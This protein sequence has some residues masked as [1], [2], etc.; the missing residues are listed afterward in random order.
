M[1]NKY[2]LPVDE[3][4]QKVIETVRRTNKIVLPLAE[5][6]GVVLAEDVVAD[7]DVPMFDRSM[8][9][10]FAV[11]SED[12]RQA[13]IESPVALKVIEEIQAGVVPMR[14]VR[15]GEAARIM[16]G[17]MIPEGAD[18]VCRFE[19]TGDG[20]RQGV[21]T[22]HV[23]RSLESGANIAR[24]GEDLPEGAAVLTEGMKIGPAEI[25]VLATFG[26]ARVAVYRKPVIAILSSGT[27]LIGVD[28]ELKP[29][30]IRNS[31]SYTVAS[32]IRQ[33]G[34][35][36]IIL[37]PVKDDVEALTAEIE[38]VLDRADMVVTTGGVSVGDYDLIPAVYDR[39][40][41][42]TIFWK[43]QMRPGSPFRFAARSDTLFFGI[44]GNPAACFVN[45]Q[46]FV[47]PALRKMVGER[48]LT[49][50]LTNAKLVNASAITP[51]KQTRFLRA[52]AFISGGQLL[53]S[54]ASGQSSGMIGSL[55]G[56]N[57]LIRLDGGKRLAEG[58]DVPVMLY[59]QVQIP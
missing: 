18:A 31:N 10:G 44:S 41:A 16:T 52:T 37:G 56:A 49:A 17:A 39:L 50:P 57:C 13:G 22:V 48:R 47:L 27:E 55:V 2:P 35:V 32:L 59:D 12:V 11:R 54:M 7:F 20:F 3:A 40:G 8:M 5:C 26:Y 53:V 51:I 29:G 24:K 9:D 4:R 28:E 19:A 33:A 34:G 46:L 6:D 42:Q 38:S 14:E 23:L 30:K 25:A 1:M 21:E 15:R 58:S 43:V 45:M 36:P